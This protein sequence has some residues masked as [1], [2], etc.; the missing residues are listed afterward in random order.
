MFFFRP[1]KIILDCF[2]H[3]PHAYDHFKLDHARKFIP[4]W[5]KSLPKE[6][7]EIDTIHLENLSK[8]QPGFTMKKCSGFISNYSEGIIFPLWSDLG[9][10]VSRDDGSSPQLRPQYAGIPSEISEHPKEQR[11]SIWPTY[12][13]VKII[14]PWFIRCNSDVQWTWNMPMWNFDELDGIQVL[15]AVIDFK[16]QLASHINI[17][18]RRHPNE[19]RS[20]ML[21]AGQ[22]LVHLVPLADDRNVEI[23]S[24]LLDKDEWIKRM[25]RG[26]TSSFKFRDIY[27]ANKKYNSCPHLDST[28]KK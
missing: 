9:F 6:L 15:P 13:H 18:I 14:S 26:D 22:P 21:E 7:N 2:T 12:Q 17:M 19:N 28:I 20:I 24:H 16:Y 10:A 25:R 4:E 3:L 5:W 23:R 11:G 1:K 8:V 27:R